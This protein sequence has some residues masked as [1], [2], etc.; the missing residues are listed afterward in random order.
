M[1]NRYILLMVLLWAMINLPG[2]NLPTIGTPEKDTL[3]LGTGENFLLIPDV[4]DGEPGEDQEIT[5]TV[6]SS[7]PGILEVSEVLYVAGNTMAVVSVLEKGQMG[8]TTLQ[9]EATD[10][11]GKASTTFEV[12]VGP[13]NNPG[14]NFEVHDIVFWQQFVPLKAN[15]AFS[16]IA[17]TGEAP[18][19]QIDLA[20]L[21]LSVYSD[22]NDS[23]PC[24]GTDFFTALFKGYLIP[25]VS[26]DYTFY[27][28]AGDRSSIGL[29]TD[30]DFGNALPII[31]NGASNP[32]VGESTADKEWKSASVSLEAGKTYAIYG[33]HWNIHT[34][35]GGMLWEGPGIGKSYIPGENLSFV[36][37]VEKPSVPADFTLVNTG[38]NDLMVSWSAATDNRSIAGY[39][40]YVNGIR[41]NSKPIGETFFHMTGLDPASR[42]CVMVTAL[43]IAGNESAE[44]NLLCT[45]TYESDAVAPN[46]PTTIEATLISDLYM[47]LAWSGATDGETEVRGYQLYLDGLLF[48]NAELIYGEEVLLT[49]LVPETD[50]L[51]EIEA[52]DAAYNVS[53]RSSGVTFTTGKFDPMDNA[54]S[55]KKARLKV[56][57]EPLGRSNGIGVNLDYKSGSFLNDADQIRLIRELET[58]AIRW[59][60]LTANPLSFA[61]YIGTGKAMTIG[62][63]MNF[64]NEVDAYTVFCCGVE[65]A[66]DWRKDPQTF[67]NFLE[68]IAGPSESTY[69]AKRAEEGFTEPLIE[70]SRGLV[71]E[72]GNEVWGGSSHDAQ[73]GTDYV[74]YGEWCREMA[75][76][77]KA[78]EYYDSTRMFL[79]YSG[80]D[81]D[82]G[83]SYGLHEKLLDGDQGEVDW[84][85][86]SGYMGGNLNYSPEIDPGKTE[87]DYYKNGIAYMSRNLDGLVST[88]DLV[89]NYSGRFKP[90]YFYESNMTHSS[91][92]GRL[93]QAIV[94]TDYYA[95]AVEKGGAIPTVFHLTGGQWKMTVPSQ[96]YKKLP[97]FY[98]TQFYNRFCKGNALKTDLETLASIP[99]YLGSE[100]KL[101]PVGCHVYVQDE[102]FSV[103]LF[104]RD[105]ANDMMVQVDLPDELALI[106]PEMGM[107]YIITGESYSAKEASI[108]SVSITM[109]DSLLVNVP[110]Y[111]MVIIS[112][113]AEESSIEDVPMGA[114]CDYVAA[115]EIDIYAYGT[116]DLDISGNQKKILLTNVFPQ[117]V[118]SDA[119][120]WTIEDHGVEV[121][122]EKKSYGFEVKGSG[123]CAGNGTITIR[124]TAW[125]NPEIFD[126][127]EINI[128]G[129]GTDCGVGVSDQKNMQVRIYPNPAGNQIFVENVPE[130]ANQMEVT[131]ITGRICLS[132]VCNGPIS[133]LDLSGLDKGIYYLRISG[134]DQVL[135]QPFIKE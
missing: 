38:I 25:T 113:G 46:P 92:Y 72:F 67:V 68:Y 7:D 106:A 94:Q 95:S 22:C 73:I 81:P 49:G 54:I 63:F 87:L 57:M 91:Y 124:A 18:Y 27:M 39:N 83:D 117:D 3:F 37:D 112:F 2:Q 80:R 15:P 114:F 44:S 93:G 79:V 47:T 85:A 43:D 31:Q 105:F 131:D 133:E 135:T 125:D 61:D 71:F 36:Y 35:M 17:P 34:L 32:I 65:D 1:T 24:T 9:V 107:K 11:D 127:V 115:T 103:V 69:G 98:T 104:S 75:G 50:Y 12:F 8:T 130:G 20:G 14:I 6:A 64:C 48:N 56:M 108:D 58:A 13:Y 84:L 96:D 16:M 110:K 86:V 82:P 121:I 19:D 78:S 74:A 134:K 4:N 123:T 55:D 60:A 62:K 45:T 89:L 102:A 126:E 90:T 42:Y 119:V 111:G 120:L 33:T 122:A 70:T 76:L 10:P 77:M 59:G 116:D 101:D 41:Y 129:Q 53:A 51:V 66:T 21:N 23:P 5:I 100:D 88:M 26:G 132:Q 99:N 97:L 30:E 128:S 29:S 52:V 118:L 28:V 109:S 40:V